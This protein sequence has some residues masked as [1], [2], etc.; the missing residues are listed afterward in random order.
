MKK[1]HIVFITCTLLLAACTA[2]GSQATINIVNH[3]PN[4]L[5]KNMPGYIGCNGTQSTLEFLS[6]NNGYIEEAPLPDSKIFE[7]LIDPSW[8]GTVTV[9]IYMAA[10]LVFDKAAKTPAQGVTPKY[11]HIIQINDTGNYQTQ[12]QITFDVTGAPI[13]SKDAYPN[14]GSVKKF[15]CVDAKGGVQIIGAY[16]QYQINNNNTI[17]TAAS[18]W[19]YGTTIEGQYG[20][21]WGKDDDSYD[22]RQHFPL[23]IY[24]VSVK[25]AQHEIT[26]TADETK[27]TIMPKGDNGKVIINQGENITFTITANSGYSIAGLLIDEDTVKPE[28]KY[29]TEYNFKSV[30]KPHTISA[31]FEEDKNAP[32]ISADSGVT[33]SLVDLIE[34]ASD[35]VVA[36]FEKGGFTGGKTIHV[37]NLD[38]DTKMEGS[39][40]A[41]AGGFAQAVKLDVKYEEGSESKGLT[42]TVK[43]ADAAKPFSADKKYYA[44]LLNKKTNYYDLFPAARN[45]S[46]NLAVKIAPVGDYFSEGTIFIY[47]GTAVESETP[48]TPVDPTTP[49]GPKSGGGCTAGIGALTLLALAP[50]YL[51]RKR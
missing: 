16:G 31:L 22:I 28:N 37:V 41:D 15:V 24:G 26:V 5:I 49:S 35:A 36:A 39:F 7:S 25:P 21:Q 40:T 34:S 11:E 38:K 50:L 13:A 8:T 32:E 45:A 33:G 2:F 42:L 23:R 1:L 44:L 47:S 6:W 18:N 14:L 12:G 9:D 43:P 48:V 19:R 20:A 10:E 46:G 29:L 4:G 51:R 3:D 17:T 30:D 27:G